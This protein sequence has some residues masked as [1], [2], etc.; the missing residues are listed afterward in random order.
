MWV[1]YERWP[2]YSI[3][4]HLPFAK[5]MVKEV[6]F[7][8]A[9]GCTCH[10]YLPL[11][12]IVRV[13]FRWLPIAIIHCKYHKFNMF[14]FLYSASSE[15]SCSLCI[16][17]FSLNN[18]IWLSVQLSWCPQSYFEIL[19]ITCLSMLHIDSVFLTIM[20][21]II[22]WKFIIHV[23]IKNANFNRLTIKS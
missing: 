2:L 5:S 10:M 4:Q 22:C 20:P 23:L 1:G 16:F 9:N 7:V 15:I 21:P 17:L 14:F 8:N 18:Y 12:E 19:L 11:L 13:W 6:N 3:T